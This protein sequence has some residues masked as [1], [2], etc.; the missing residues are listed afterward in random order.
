MKRII[1]NPNQLPCIRITII[2]MVLLSGLLVV[3]RL[4]TVNSQM[5]RAIKAMA[6]TTL[7]PGLEDACFY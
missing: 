5:K 3:C 6:L 7:M 2:M 1:A 4:F